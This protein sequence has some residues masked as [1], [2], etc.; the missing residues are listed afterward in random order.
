MPKGK[1]EVTGDAVFRAGDG[2][3]LTKPV[4]PPTHPHAKYE[5]QYG[6]MRRCHLCG[7]MEDHLN[8][9]A[10][11]VWFATLEDK[12]RHIIEYHNDKPIEVQRAKEILGISELWDEKDAVKVAKSKSLLGIPMGR[13]QEEGPELP[14]SV[15][16]PFVK[17]ESA[18]KATKPKSWFRRHPLLTILLLFIIVYLL[19]VIWR[20]MQGY[21]F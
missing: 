5:Y 16:Q 7:T 6:E 8:H 1:E 17:E 11:P 20:Y 3:P 21:H 13:R 2:T 19:M 9:T 15:Q 14:P 4:P 10:E 18:K 12:A